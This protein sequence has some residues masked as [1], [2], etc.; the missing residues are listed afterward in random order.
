MNSTPGAGIAVLSKEGD[1]AI[2]EHRGR[3]DPRTGRRARGRRGRGIGH[4]VRASMIRL[5]IKL[6]P[7]RWG[8][9]F[10]TPSAL[11]AGPRA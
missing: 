3:S 7:R 10:K 11:G 6:E 8:L 4:R 5:T 1:E 9:P 2:L